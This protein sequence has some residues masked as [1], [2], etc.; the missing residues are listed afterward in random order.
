MRVRTGTDLLNM[1]RAFIGGFF[2]SRAF[3]ACI[4]YKLSMNI[5]KYAFFYLGIF[6]GLR[7]HYPAPER[8]QGAG[9]SPSL[10][11]LM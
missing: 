3:I 8:F 9:R 11:P 5:D 6:L 4:I 2:N 1:S 7:V 10:P